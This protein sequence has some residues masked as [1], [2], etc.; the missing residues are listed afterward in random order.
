MPDCLFDFPLL[1][2]SREVD[3]ELTAPGRL[4][5]AEAGLSDNDAFKFGGASSEKPGICEG[6]QGLDFTDGELPRD[7]TGFFAST[8]RAFDADE[9]RVGGP[10]TLGAALEGVDDLRV[11]V[12]DLR[13]SLAADAPAALEGVDDLLV[14]GVEVREEALVVGVDDLTSGAV[15]FAE[16]NVARE[17]GVEGLEDLVVEGNVGLPEGVADLGVAVVAPPDDEGLLFAAVEEPNPG[18][19][20]TLFLKAGSA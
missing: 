6:S 5:E 3:L 18:L 19:E 20:A 1:P 2:T 13:V 9:A 16:L 7:G 14:V 17:V 8:G 15:C 11:G 12:D 4:L 10:D